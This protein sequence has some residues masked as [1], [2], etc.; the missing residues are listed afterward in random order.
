MPIAWTA[1]TSG[2]R[3]CRWPSPPHRPSPGSS[4]RSNSRARTSAPGAASSAG[5]RSLT[6]AYSTT[7]ASGSFVAWK[8]PSWRR[9]PCLATTSS[10]FK[11][12]SRHCARQ[13]SPVRKHRFAGSVRSWWLRRSRPNPLLLHQWEAAG[14]GRPPACPGAG[15]RWKSDPVAVVHSQRSTKATVRQSCC[16]SSGTSCASTSYTA[17][18]SSPG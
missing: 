12:S 9:V 6:E 8:G 10:I 16:P 18:R 3:L 17:S 7:S 14:R 1:S 2:W 15:I 5:W 11:P 13:A 4:R